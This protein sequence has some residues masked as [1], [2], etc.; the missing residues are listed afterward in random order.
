MKQV[1]DSDIFDPC[2]D[3]SYKYFAFK[4]L[5]YSIKDLEVV[6]LYKNLY[7]YFEVSN[8]LNLHFCI[9]YIQGKQDLWY[10]VKLSM[11]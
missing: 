6:M 4:I 5:C 9:L 2:E 11:N 10:H 3:A 8:V 7:F 1:T